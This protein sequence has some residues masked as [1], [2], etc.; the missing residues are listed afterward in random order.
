MNQL[1]LKHSKWPREVVERARSRFFGRNPR[2]GSRSPPYLT[3]EPI[4]TTTWVS[5]KDC[6]FLIMA[7]DGLWDNLSS[8][9]A[10]ELVGQWLQT[11][12]PSFSP[13]PVQLPPPRFYGFERQLTEVRREPRQ[14]GCPEPNKAYTKDVWNSGK[15]FVIK[16]DNAATHLA[17]N[18][19]GGGDED[20]LR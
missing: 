9:Q 4:I 7:S 19:L 1:R 14:R 2:P 16:D 17:R 11:N 18:A 8:K 20:L 10:V 12:D 5:P 13:A 6:D 3:A 15:Q